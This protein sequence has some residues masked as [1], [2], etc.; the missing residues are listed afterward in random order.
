VKNLKLF[1]GVVMNNAAHTQRYK[2]RIKEA[3]EFISKREPILEN[4]KEHISPSGNYKLVVFPRETGEGYWNYMEGIVYNKKEEDIFIIY[5]NYSSFPFR[6]VEHKNGNEY[7]LCGEDYQGY[8][9]LNLTQKK[10]HVYF[11]ESGFKG[12]GFCWATIGEYNRDND[13]IIVEGCHWGGQYEVIEYDF[14]KPDE[15]PYKE[16]SRKDCEIEDDWDED[17][18][19]EE[20]E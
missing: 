11:P 6:W 5:R 13:T 3:K 1:V 20:E 4:K 10:K 7:L 14:S 18:D 9:C 15:M 19:E 2:D 17:E 12:G 16:I 8:V